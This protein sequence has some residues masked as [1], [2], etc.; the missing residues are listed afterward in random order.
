M[1]TT[2]LFYNWKY[3]P[4]DSF[5]HFHP[6]PT[7]AH[8]NHQSL[9]V[10]FIYKFFVVTYVSKII[11]LPFSDLFHLVYCSQ[12]PLFLLQIARFHSFYGWIIFMYK[13]SSFA[14]SCPTFCDPINRSMPGLPVHHQLPEFT[15][16]HLHWVGDAIQSSH[17]LSSPSPPALSLS[18]HQ[19]L[20]KWVSSPHWV[21]KVLEFQLQHQSLQWTP[22]TEL[23]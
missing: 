2:Y 17:P 22:S 12:G 16:T 18:H 7:T 1:P 9:S 13:F 15:Q 23:L 19:G 11:Y 5:H 20:Y 3:V 6:S 10:L 14:Q 4:L 8:G 21:A